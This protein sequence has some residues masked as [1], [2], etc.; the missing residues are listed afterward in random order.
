MSITLEHNE[1]HRTQAKALVIEQFK[2]SQRFN[3]WLGAYIGQVQDLEDALW[4]L[5]TMRG[6]DTAEGVQLDVLGVIVGQPR[7]GLDDEDYRTRI[8]V[9][10]RLNRA[11]GIADDIYAV[12]G[13]MLG[14]QIGA[15]DLQEVYPA[16]LIV[17]MNEYVA[18]SPSVLADILREARGAGIDTSLVWL[19]SEDGIFECSAAAAPVTGSIDEGFAGLPP[20]VSSFAFAT[21]FTGGCYAEGLYLIAGVSGA[22]RIQTSVSGTSYTTAYTAS[23]GQVND[24]VHSPALGMF[25][26]CGQDRA[27]WS[28]DGLAW[29][30]V[31]V[32]SRNWTQILWADHLAKFVAF[33]ITNPYVLM[34]SDGTNWTDTALTGATGVNTPSGTKGIAYSP[35]LQRFISVYSGA[36]LKSS[37]DGVAWTDHGAFS[38]NDGVVWSDVLGAF[39]ACDS[40]GGIAYSLDGITGWTSLMGATAVA[41]L[42]AIATT[43]GV[44]VL[45]IA[46]GIST[47]AY[48]IT[49]D[50]NIITFALSS[51]T[52]GRA[53]DGANG[54]IVTVTSGTAASIITGNTYT[55]GELAGV[56]EA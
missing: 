15:V 16:G 29:T 30:G 33:N 20:T 54:T 50:F 1:D 41:T 38:Y 24:V 3:D 42:Y 35:T 4:Q 52:S 26:A 44:V 17:Q 13:L 45:T 22:S 6:V 49:A 37:T 32:A 9:R 14:N 36:T 8:K 55:G 25:A 47:D 21:G 39:V 31:V 18:T 2:R 46:G 23:A 53:V 12:F 43:Y 27:H 11:S 7:L 19:P 10:I 51:T 28:L 40:G 34:S 48:L 5:Y 56:L